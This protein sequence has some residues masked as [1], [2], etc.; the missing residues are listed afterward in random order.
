MLIQISPQE[1]LRGAPF[2][3]GI[4]GRFIH[5][6]DPVHPFHVQHDSALERDDEAGQRHACAHGHDR[7]LFP[8]RQPHDSL[9]LFNGSRDDHIIRPVR[10]H[11]PGIAGV[12]IHFFRLIGD[13]VSP[14]HIRQGLQNGIHELIPPFGVFHRSPCGRGRSCEWA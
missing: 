11:E 12:E 13:I 5:F 14:D 3:E 7:Y 8:S 4:P 6:Q 10:R 2:H 9:D 1:P